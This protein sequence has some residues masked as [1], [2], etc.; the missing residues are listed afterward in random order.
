MLQRPEHVCAEHAEGETH[1]CRAPAKLAG[2]DKIAQ[3]CLG[4][5]L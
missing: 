4:Q 3:Q 1:N 5:T 2:V